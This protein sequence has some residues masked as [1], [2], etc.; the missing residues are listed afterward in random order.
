MCFV[1]LILFYAHECGFLMKRTFLILS[2]GLI[3]ALA[4]SYFVLKLGDKQNVKYLFRPALFF[5]SALFIVSVGLKSSSVFGKATCC[6]ACVVFAFFI[7]VVLI[8]G[9]YYA[10][11]PHGVTQDDVFALLQSDPTESTDFVFRILLT[12]PRVLVGFFFAALFLFLAWLFKSNITFTSRKVRFFVVIAACAGMLIGLMQTRCVRMTLTAVEDYQESLDVFNE[13]YRFLASQQPIPIRKLGA[14]EIYVIVIGESEGRDYMHYY[15]DIDALPNTPWLDAASRSENLVVFDNAYSHHTHTVP[16]VT[17]ALTDGRAITGLTFPKGQNLIS[18]ARSAGMQTAWISNQYALGPYDSPYAAIAHLAD[19]TKYVSATDLGKARVLD[20]AIIPEFSSVLEKRQPGSNQTVV[21]HLMGSH[22]PYA[23]RLPAQNVEY[24]IEGDCF[25][26]SASKTRRINFNRY[27]DTIRYTDSTLRELI[28]ALRKYN[29]LSA[30]LVYFSDHGEDVFSKDGD[31][32]YKF[33]TWSKAR[34]PVFVWMSD[35]YMRRYPEK[36]ASLRGNAQRVFTND[37]VFDL[38]CGLAG[39]AEAPS[40]LS[41]YDISSPHYSL[42]PE[43]ALLS[44]GRMVADDPD[45][46]WKT[47]FAQPCGTMVGMA[48]CLSLGKSIKAMAL[49]AS[50]IES[51]I[52]WTADARQGGRKTLRVGSA[53][54]V[55][56]TF[57]EWVRALPVMPKRLYLRVGDMDEAQWSA[58]IDELNR[59]A[60]AEQVRARAV[61]VSGSEPLLA[62]FKNQGWQ[63]CQETSGSVDGD[64][65]GSGCVF[66]EAATLED[67]KALHNALDEK[68]LGRVTTWVLKLSRPADPAGSEVKNAFKNLYDILLMPYESY[69]NIEHEQGI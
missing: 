29:H 9:Q 56:C 31:H 2:I 33:F 62:F 42:T 63:V 11:T 5:L 22:Q 43:T 55:G 14:D 41:R 17:A 27:A 58:M 39:L 46:R 61:L 26:G 45:M 12:V 34:I 23:D 50:V 38:Y 54:Y 28:E 18:L 37:L 21:V 53:E 35:A 64:S 24:S 66:Y 8:L 65:V 6:I 30:A 1:A 25:F 7:S 32:D 47:A 40:Y 67:A 68:G 59:T 44:G 10:L 13:S 51:S 57:D 16:N 60:Q 19:Y 48:D 20:S 69:F 4:V 49:G 36:T 52:I 15:S 3:W